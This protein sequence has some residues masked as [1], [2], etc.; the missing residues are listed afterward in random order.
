VGI[1]KM[2]YVGMRGRLVGDASFVEDDEGRVEYAVITVLVDRN[3]SGL[4]NIGNKV[5]EGSGF[6]VSIKNRKMLR[7]YGFLLKDGV[8]VVVHGELDSNKGIDCKLLIVVGE[9]REVTVLLDLNEPEDDIE[10][11]REGEG[12][13]EV[14]NLN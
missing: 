12:G 7:R 5:P 3:H 9:G 4:Q 6:D 10:E 2:N 13:Q 11:F 1:R 14:L 8:R